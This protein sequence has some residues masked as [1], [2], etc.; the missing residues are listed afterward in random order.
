MSLENYP[1]FQKNREMDSRLGDSYKKR[2][3]LKAELAFDKMLLTHVNSADVKLDGKN[4]RAHLISRNQHMY[5]LD[6]KVSMREPNKVGSILEWKDSTFLL[7]M[8]EKVEFEP[9]YKYTARETNIVGKM[10]ISNNEYNIPA[11][12]FTSIMN[13]NAFDK[14]FL[15]V[16]IVNTLNCN[17]YVLLPQKYLESI[18]ESLVAKHLFFD[19][20]RW[21]INSVNTT[22]VKGI[23]VCG[24]TKL[25][26]NAIEEKENEN[27]NSNTGQYFIKG[28]S[29]IM[30][31]MEN[32]YTLSHAADSINYVLENLELVSSL[33]KT[34]TVKPLSK[35]EATISLTKDGKVVSKKVIDVLGFF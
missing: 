19:E 12:F 13:S 23:A 8:Q 29:E 33:Y 32:T 15:E 7:I 5:Q 20:T 17:G 26:K 34:I 4:T 35:G 11:Y 10:V 28:D 25:E 9:A 16:A 24:L 21:Q 18:T 1:M 14:G 2:E 22:S 30:L 27:V 31:G 6:K 3:L